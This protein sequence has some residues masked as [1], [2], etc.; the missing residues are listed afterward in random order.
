ML[1]RPNKIIFSLQIL[2]NDKDILPMRSSKEYRKAPN[3]MYYGSVP[4]YSGG[5][6]L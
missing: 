6:V 3:L 1:H 5:G 2:T 4:M